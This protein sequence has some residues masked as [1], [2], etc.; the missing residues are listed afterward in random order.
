MMFILMFYTFFTFICTVHSASPQ[1]ISPSEGDVI[2]AGSQFPFQYR[3]TADYGISSYNYTVW[4]FTTPPTTVEPS[5]LFA[6]GYF[7]GRFSQPNYPGG[8]CNPYPQNQPPS[9][10]IMPNFSKGLGGFGAGS[11]NKTQECYFVVL[12]EYGTGVAAAGSRISWTET[13]IIYIAN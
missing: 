9:A 11:S 7:F 1:I 3:T 13:K 4:L 8:H 6:T 12:E 2:V 10:F 5:N